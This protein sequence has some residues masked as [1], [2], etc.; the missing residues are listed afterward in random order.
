MARPTKQGINYFPLDCAFDNKTEMYLMET[1]A[2]GLA[3][4]VTLW[5]M[6]YSNNGYYVDNCDDLKLLIKRRID[7]GIN[8]VS[9]LSLI[10]I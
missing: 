3:V 5:Q 4:I 9:D 6:I 8:E 7:V 10:H 1:G 2:N